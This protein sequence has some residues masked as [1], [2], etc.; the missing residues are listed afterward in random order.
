MESTIKKFTPEPDA[1][2]TYA[3][4]ESSPNNYIWATR[5][6]PVKKYVDDII[7]EYV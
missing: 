5:T 7:F 1:K 2:G 6:T 3:I 4:K